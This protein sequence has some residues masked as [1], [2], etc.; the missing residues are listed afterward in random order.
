MNFTMHSILVCSF[1]NLFFISSVNVDGAVVFRTSYENVHDTYCLMKLLYENVIVHFPLKISGEQLTDLLFVFYFVSYA[2]LYI[3]LAK[4]CKR[5]S[6]LPF[7]L[8]STAVFFL[9]IFF[10]FHQLA[11]Q[12]LCVCL[13]IVY[14]DLLSFK[15]TRY[16]IFVCGSISSF[17]T[18]FTCFGC[19]SC[20]TDGKIRSPNTI[21]GLI[22][23]FNMR[24]TD[25]FII[26][27]ES[28]QQSCKK[29]M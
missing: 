28:E 20:V 10:F 18:P 6:F 16:S 2:V 26:I 13:P 3:F 1:S 9:F 25:F 23:I 4:Q 14:S 15:F 11:V 12:C 7:I 19:I 27:Y 17:L 5:F 29:Y 24:Y 8:H 21:H 22:P